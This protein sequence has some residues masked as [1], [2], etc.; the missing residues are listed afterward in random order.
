MKSTSKTAQKQA[1][2]TKP[3][4]G[5]NIRL[6]E[7]GTYQADVRIGGKRKRKQ[8]DE[9]DGAKAFIDKQIAERDQFGELAN[10]MTSK[11]I[12]NAADALH[13]I[14]DAGFDIDLI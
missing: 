8:F 12:Q 5:G 11:Q 7:W 3:Y 13:M 1:T 10:A 4:S 6:T 2:E 9:L 14:Q